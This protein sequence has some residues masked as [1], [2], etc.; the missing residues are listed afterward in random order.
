ELRRR[1]R[2]GL[3]AHMTIVSLK[4]KYATAAFLTVLLGTLIVMSL[5]AW[6]HEVDSR[7]LSTVAEDYTRD[8]VAREL[9]ARATAFA[10]HAAEAAA[11]ALR[12]GTDTALAQP[13]QRFTDDQTLAAIVVRNGSGEVRFQWHRTG[14]LPPQ[15]LQWQALQT[16]RS[17]VA[18]QPGGIE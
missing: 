15:T 4:L 11:P 6:Q 12:A 17:M 5:L 2:T 18:S 9:Q 14:P 3:A 10:R 8:H 16:I 1:P 13:M 7:Q